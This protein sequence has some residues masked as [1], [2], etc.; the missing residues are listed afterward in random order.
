MAA[1]L[2]LIRDYH[3]DT[4]SLITQSDDET[5]PRTRTVEV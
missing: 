1:P 3:M 2:M 5:L 4:S